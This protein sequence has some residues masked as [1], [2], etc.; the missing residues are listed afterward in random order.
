M[1]RCSDVMQLDCFAVEATTTQRQLLE[2]RKEGWEMDVQKTRGKKGKA[3][4]RKDGKLLGRTER[5]MEERTGEN[6]ET[7]ETKEGEITWE[8]AKEKIKKEKSKGRGEIDSI[9]A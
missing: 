9:I 6:V 1:Q 7:D 8:L 3:V 2:E 5:G 4:E